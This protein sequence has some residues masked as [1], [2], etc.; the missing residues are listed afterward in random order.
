MI[1]I[2]LTLVIKE[3]F[4]RLVSVTQLVT[5]G[6]ILCR[7]WNSNLKFS[8]APYIMCVNIVIKQLDKNKK[9]ISPTWLHIFI[10]SMLVRLMKL[11]YPF[12]LKRF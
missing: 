1:S 8:I 2:N 9:I 12:H 7:S 4:H 5:S 3:V 11:D 10:V 6:D